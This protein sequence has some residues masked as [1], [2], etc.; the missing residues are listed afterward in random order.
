MG[1]R[2]ASRAEAKAAGLEAVRARLVTGTGPYPEPKLIGQIVYLASMLVQA[3]QRPGR[4]AAI[5]LER[6]H[7]DLEEC[8]ARISKILETD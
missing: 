8:L 5:R 7:M 6:L 1:G 2:E 3:D 4:D